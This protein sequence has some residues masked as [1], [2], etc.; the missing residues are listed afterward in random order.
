MT[1]PYIS[2]RGHGEIC[3]SVPLLIQDVTTWGFLLHAD[4]GRLQ[5]FI[6][7]QLNRV[8][9]GKVRYEALSVPLLGRSPIFHAYLHAGRCTSTSETIGWLPDHESA[10][11]VPVLQFRE[12]ALLPE[13]RTWVPYLL[14]DD[15]SGMVTGREVWGY[16]KSL[17]TITTPAVPD[18]AA[19]LSASTTIFSKLAP[20]TQG[21]RATLL[22][23]TRTGAH[24]PSPSQWGSFEEAAR[25]IFTLGLGGGILDL[26]LAPIMDP[27]FRGLAI[28]VINLKQIRDA[29]DSTRAC[30]SAL[31]ESPCQVERWKGGGFLQGDYEI[32]ITTCE[33]HQIATDLGLGTPSGG[34][35]VRVRPLTAWWAQLDF[36][37]PRGSVVWQAT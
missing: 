37:T 27:F 7:D 4:S 6:D 1:V 26:A 33:S 9:G 24:V 10:F 30:Y 36:S 16:R 31:V 25:A 32:E 21:R 3:F 29:I 5:A 18:D 19:E 23:A 28:N 20:D 35:P 15:Q 11:L 2:D 22:K 34:A 14:I 17:A 13:L 12:G 8:S